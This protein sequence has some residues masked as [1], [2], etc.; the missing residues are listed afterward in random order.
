MCSR[1]GIR[2]F[3]FFLLKVTLT[4]T[5]VH[6]IQKTL[7]STQGEHQCKKEGIVYLD[8]VDTLS[9]LRTPYTYCKFL[10]NLFI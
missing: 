3:F 8:C 1:E 4:K 9:A 6:P 7:I 10:G 2:F 5:N